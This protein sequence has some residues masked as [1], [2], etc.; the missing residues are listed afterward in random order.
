M[1]EVLI[2]H[3][4]IQFLSIAASMPLSC[5]LILFRLYSQHTCLEESLLPTMLLSVTRSR[6]SPSPVRPLRSASLPPRSLRLMV[7]TTLIHPIIATVV[8]PRRRTAP[9]PSQSAIRL[10][11]SLARRWRR[12]ADIFRFRCSRSWV[13]RALSA[14]SSLTDELRRASCRDVEA[15]WVI[16]VGKSS[17]GQS[18]EWH[19]SSRGGELRG[20]RR[21]AGVFRH[22][23]SRGFK[24]GTLGASP[25]ADYIREPALCS[26]SDVVAVWIWV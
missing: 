6:L 7:S 1:I 24:L 5:P 16:W 18:R 17:R 21:R 11:E 22:N 23:C 2:V 20:R 8:S 26:R 25:L 3:S 13:H 10:R 12:R 4:D 15:V 14:T 19:S 9:R